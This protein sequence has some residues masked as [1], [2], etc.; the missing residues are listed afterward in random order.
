M[1]L[2]HCRARGLLTQ[3]R[4]L[5][6]DHRMLADSEQRQVL[7]GA[8]VHR[9]SPSRVMETAAKPSTFTSSSNAGRVSCAPNPDLI[10]SFRFEPC[11]IGSPP[12]VRRLPLQEGGE[13]LRRL[14]GV[15]R[16]FGA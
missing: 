13:A 8:D 2:E 3:D 16:K 12:C 5:L 1:R 7:L 10:L 15:G 9:R 14:L 6:L 11:Q 4:K